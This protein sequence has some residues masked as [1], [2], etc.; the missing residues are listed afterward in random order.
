MAEITVRKQPVQGRALASCAAILEAAAQL[1]KAGEGVNT[2]AIAA[3]AGVSIGTLYQYFPGKEAILAELVR[4]LRA[5]MLADLEGAAEAA[6]GR[7]LKQSVGLMIGAALAHHR[8]DAALAAALERVEAEL[9]MDAETARL[10]AAIGGL[11]I[12]VLARFNLPD[13]ERAA[14]DLSA[15]TRGMA[16]AA[17][18][19][20]ER[21][22]DSVAD[23]IEL[24]AMGYLRA[25]RS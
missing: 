3:R 9:P 7:N 6:R 1:L 24:A 10:K 25:V 21:D 19:A 16:E 23:R 11:V 22:F 8:R 18:R 17:A 13:P 20:A 4:G 2:N 15:I 12:S 14:Q 5:E